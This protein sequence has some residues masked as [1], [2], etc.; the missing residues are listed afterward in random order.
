METGNIKKVIKLQ[1]LCI[2]E[3]AL[4]SNDNDNREEL[5]DIS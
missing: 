4:D 2:H 5:D 1:R 3:Y